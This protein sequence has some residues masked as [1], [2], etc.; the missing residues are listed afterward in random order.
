MTLTPSLVPELSVSDL[1]RS[2]QFYCEAL[3]FSKRYSR[4]EEGFAFIEFGRACLMLDQLGVGRDWV[5]APM[6]APF[7]RGINLQIAVDRLD[8]LLDRLATQSIR[9]FLAVED[10]RY[11]IGERVVTQRQFCVQDPDGYLLR[12]CETA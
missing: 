4:P 3:G 11:R 6:Q 10:K 1:G 9:L 7:G 5:T 8:P 2:L 12:F